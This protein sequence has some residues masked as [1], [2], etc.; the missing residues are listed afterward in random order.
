MIYSPNVVISSAHHELWDV[1]RMSVEL[2][3]LLAA[4]FLVIL[5]RLF[6]ARTHLNSKRLGKAF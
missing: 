1:H 4:K 5:A 6:V 3:A 2:L